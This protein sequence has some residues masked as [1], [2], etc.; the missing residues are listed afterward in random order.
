MFMN[1]Q[2]RNSLVHNAVP[3]VFNFPASSGMS[4]VKSEKKRKAPTDRS[5]IVVAKKSKTNPLQPVGLNVSEYELI[6]DIPPVTNT[7][8]PISTDV[9]TPRKQL[10]RSQ[11]AYTKTALSRAR[12]CLFRLRKSKR[13]STGQVGARGESAAQARCTCTL[14]QDFSCLPVSQRQF[15][16]SQVKACRYSKYGMR[17]SVQDKMLALGLFYKSPSAYRFMS[18]SF[19]LPS[20]R[21]L[22]TFIGGFSIVCGFKSEYVAALKK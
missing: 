12:V 2:T 5:Q 18:S 8:T 7:S 6:V 3:T 22:Q 14:C 9:V 13:L 4:A 20:E 1:T 17:F 16:E 15:F 19:R 10:L 21:T 11:L